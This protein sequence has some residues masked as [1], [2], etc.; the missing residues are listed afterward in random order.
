MIGGWGYQVAHPLFVVSG[1][2]RSGRPRG[3]PWAMRGG[4]KHGADPEQATGPAVGPPALANQESNPTQ[5]T[6][7]SRGMTYLTSTNVW[8]KRRAASNRGNAS[9]TRAGTG[10]RADYSAEAG[11]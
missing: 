1:P 9:G 8:R 7:R 6:D 5:F 2:V 3:P 4:R 10:A 11:P